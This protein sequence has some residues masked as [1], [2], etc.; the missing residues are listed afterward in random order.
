MKKEQNLER[1]L[2]IDVGLEN[3]L[4]I[5]NLS[6]SFRNFRLRRFQKK[7][8]DSDVKHYFSKNFACGALLNA[9]AMTNC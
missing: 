8:L 6:P 7:A 4:E 9:L 1:T 2:K 3:G 5:R